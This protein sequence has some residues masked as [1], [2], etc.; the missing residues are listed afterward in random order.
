MDW[1]KTKKLLFTK[2]VWLVIIANIGV[3]LNTSGIFDDLA[4]DKYRVI[5]TSILLILEV[6]GIIGVYNTEPNDINK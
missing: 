2:S 3:I 4:I 1:N 5:S 6:V